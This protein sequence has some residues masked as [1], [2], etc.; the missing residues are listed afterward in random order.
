[1]APLRTERAL[2]LTAWRWWGRMDRDQGRETGQLAQPMAAPIASLVRC[3]RQID[4]RRV[5]TELTRFAVVGMRG[6]ARS[7]GRVRG[8]KRFQ[9]HLL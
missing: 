1:M 3:D 6:E 4:G 2:R 5:A 8:L 7:G 9:R